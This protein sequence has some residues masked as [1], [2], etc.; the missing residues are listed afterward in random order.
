LQNLAADVTYRWSWRPL[1]FL[2]RCYRGEG[3][4]RR[5]SACGRVGSL[6]LAFGSAQ[7]NCFCAMRRNDQ[8]HELSCAFGA[9]ATFLCLARETWPKE[10]PPHLALVG[11]PAQQVREPGPGFSNGHPARAKRHRHPVDASCAA[12][13]PRLTAAQGPP[14]RAAGLPGPHS[15]EDPQQQKARCD[16]VILHLEEVL[17][18]RCQMVRYRPKQTFHQQSFVNEPRRWSSFRCRRSR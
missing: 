1:R 7:K 13:R 16:S 17:A 15:S 18:G 4:D 12:C 2:C 8:E 14:G 11:P 5:K 3:C 6:D 10:R 9:R